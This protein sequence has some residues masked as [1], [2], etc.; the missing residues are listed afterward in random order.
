MTPHLRSA[1][2]YY[3]L[4]IVAFLL[5]LGGLPTPAREFEKSWPAVKSARFYEYELSLDSGFTANGLVHQGRVDKPA[6]EVDLAPGAYYLRVRAITENG[7]PG[8]WSTS[9]KIAVS[10]AGAQFRNPA[11]NTAIELPSE[12]SPLRVEWES[13]EGAQDYE[14]QAV[15]PSL[16]IS[17]TVVTPGPSAQIKGLKAGNWFLEVVAR[18]KG[19][20]LSKSKALP[21]KIDIKTFPRPRFL[22]PQEEDVIA[23]FELFRIRWHR[24]TP[25]NRSEVTVKR[26]DEG[27]YTVSRETVEDSTTTFI[28]PLP[29][30][31]YQIT[32]KDFIKDAADSVQSSV[33]IYVKEDPLGRHTQFLGG[34]LRVL[35]F[36]HR[37]INHFENQSDYDEILSP[38]GKDTHGIEIRGTA[39]IWKAW[40]VDSTVLGLFNRPR[41]LRNNPS[42]SDFYEEPEGS[43]GEIHVHL[44]PTYT[45][46][47]FGPTKPMTFKGQLG[48]SEK[49]YPIYFG[50]GAIADANRQ[51]FKEGHFKLIDMKLSSEIRLGGWNSAW[52]AVLAASIGFPL[53]AWGHHVGPGMP[54]PYPSLQLQSLVRRK[55]FQELRL[56]FGLSTTLERINVGEE[57][58]S[59]FRIIRTMVTWAP[60]IGIEI[61][62]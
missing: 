39:K 59:D 1:Q 5:L 13:V 44:G 52:D 18:K 22:Q 2:K 34:N 40:G 50:S 48:W 20:F 31:R 8:P 19:E 4:N 41:F 12:E 25:G 37:G 60:M 23:T 29:A 27:P 56:N 30:G 3:L 24:Q 21:I 47:P 15:N 62:I 38:E 49:K 51:E 28:P 61:D 10:G 16:K 33:T 58:N 11:P 55:F 7:E 43:Y 17:R 6:M 36:F 26:L 9:E 46:N 32:V 42:G 14:L 35:N 54:K 45:F 53:W 57:N